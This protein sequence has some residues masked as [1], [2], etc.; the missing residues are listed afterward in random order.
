MDSLLDQGRNYPH[1]WTKLISMK[2]HEDLFSI[3]PP[4]WPIRDTD[5][6]HFNTDPDHFNTDPYPRYEKMC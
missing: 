6:D 1:H 2:N 3:I 4:V 5:P